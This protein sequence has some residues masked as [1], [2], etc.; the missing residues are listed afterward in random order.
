MSLKSVKCE[1][2]IY[3]DP[4]Y[5]DCELFQFRLTDSALRDLE[6]YATTLGG[7]TFQL[8]ISDTQN[9]F[10]IPL[11]GRP[12]KFTFGITNLDGA[13]DGS[14]DCL[15]INQGRVKCMGKVNSRITV[16]AK[17]DSFSIAREKMVQLE[18]E[19]KKSQ[20]KEIGMR[21]RQM[22]KL[23]SSYAGSKNHLDSVQE[24]TSHPPEF[25]S[26]GSSHTS[27]SPQAPAPLGQQ[28]TQSPHA[29][30]GFGPSLSLPNTAVSVRPLRERIIHLLALRPYQRNELLLRLERDGL[31][32]AQKT[33][34]DDLLS[35]VSR[36]GRRSAYHILPSI[37]P[38][39]DPSW[40]GYPAGEKGRII[41]L[42]AKQRTCSPST[43]SPPSRSHTASPA[44]VPPKPLITEDEFSRRP[45]RAAPPSAP[46]P[47][48]RK[49]AALDLLS[50]GVSESDVSAR[51]GVCKELLGHWRAAEK[52]LRERYA[53]QNQKSDTRPRSPLANTTNSSSRSQTNLNASS[54]TRSSQ[55]SIYGPSQN[56][57]SLAADLSI[58]PSKR[59]RVEQLSNSV[60]P[61]AGP[62]CRT[63]LKPVARAVP[64]PIVHSLVDSDN[65][66][67]S[68]GG[69]D[70]V[71]RPNLG[72]N[73]QLLSPP[74]LQ[75]S[76]PQTLFDQRQTQF[77]SLSGGTGSEGESASHTP[78]SNVSSGSSTHGTTAAS[79]PSFL[80]NNC[81]TVGRPS[82]SRSFSQAADREPLRNCLFPDRTNRSCD[83][84]DVDDQNCTERET[85]LC[86]NESDA[87]K[88]SLHGTSHSMGF[89]EIQSADLALRI[90]EIN[91]LYPRICTVDQI[92]MYRTEFQ[93]TYPTYLRMYHSFSDIWKAVS[94]LRSRLLEATK[95]DGLD[96]HLTGSLADQLDSFLRR[97]RTQKYRDDQAQLTLMAHKLRLLK[98]RLLESRRNNAFD[99]RNRL[100][101]PASPAPQ[102]SG[103][104]RSR[105][106]SKQSVGHIPNPLE[107][108]VMELG[109]KQTVR[110]SDQARGVFAPG[111]RDSRFDRL[112]VS[113]S[114]QTAAV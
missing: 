104:K 61:S 60:R 17:E 33:Q 15:C 86:D 12:G 98:R 88:L 106:Q 10:T 72:E 25:R 42:K 107:H 49:I 97:S 4:S 75:D 89:D 64:E 99:P 48:S 69:S 44:N 27:H 74:S 34:L 46:H 9:S 8:R 2:F 111:Q 37:I 96:S 65:R 26:G 85:R 1:N 32:T 114:G 92:E 79:H 100:S 18:D 82:Q 29:P 35:Q 110:G 108:Q 67:F 14:V 113:R 109:T 41:S 20:T 19:G 63:S 56:T 3:D 45:T 50:S 58:S 22:N 73:S 95:T 55:S 91:R 78:C 57:S 7:D 30:S 54:H 102:N 11:P 76:I 93:S 53:R 47:L 112:E 36:V 80:T 6:K 5:R 24:G 31:T 68:S 66:H 38:E 43:T 23:G 39:L 28:H 83:L 90:A 87:A 16:N 62:N 94:N 77:C 84:D 51:L 81:S 13:T 52:E 103:L 59:P 21:K 105:S 101:L 71:I 70:E 40:P